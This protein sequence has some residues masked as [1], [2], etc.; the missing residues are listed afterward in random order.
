MIRA[1]TR[2]ACLR[3]DVYN[4]AGEVEGGGGL[5]LREGGGRG[6]LRGCGRE[7]ERSSSSMALE[8]RALGSFGSVVNSAK[9]NKVITNNDS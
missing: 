2:L 7:G 8:G 5:L 4:L 6:I 1:A 9:R 3:V